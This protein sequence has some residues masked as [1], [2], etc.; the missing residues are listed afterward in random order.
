MDSHGDARV[1]NAGCAVDTKIEDT[2]LFSEPAVTVTHGTES[3]SRRADADSR[4]RASLSARPE[5]VSRKRAKPSQ[6]RATLALL[7]IHGST[8]Q[9]LCLK[10]SEGPI[11]RD[12]MARLGNSFSQRH[13]MVMACRKKPAFAEATAGPP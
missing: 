2:D 7:R 5:S 11:A 3:V 9:F 6:P 10:R 13:G 4:R 12:P 1:G 8:R